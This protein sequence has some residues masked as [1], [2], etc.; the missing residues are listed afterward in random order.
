MII[1]THAHIIVPE[2]TR[3]AQP[4]DRWRPQVRWEG[5]QQ[6]IAFANA[7]IRSAIRECVRIDAILEIQAALGV[8]RIVLS[9]W[10]SLLRY[11]AD[12]QDGLRVSRIQNEALAKLVRGHPDRLS[13]LGTVPLQEP[14]LASRELTRL[15][16]ELGL[17][18]VVIS[19]PAHSISLGDDRFRPFWEIAEATGALV[20]FHP[21]TRGFA[22]PA[23]QNYYL[24]NAVGNPVE[25]TVAAA[26][27]IMAGTMERH[28]RL[29]VLLAHGGGAVIALRGRLRHAWDVQPEA[30]ARLRES[31]ER[32][33]ARFYF[34]SLTQ[35]SKVLQDLIDAV[36]ADH[37][38]LGSDYPFDMGVSDPAAMVRA[39]HLPADDE[40]KILGR[41]AARLLGIH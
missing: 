17:S 18:G 29:K 9:P 37:V 28:P 6:V 2:I 35:D 5:T 22:L 14:A 19:T 11:D 16:E 27:L 41:N 8:D 33:L 1:D 32:S 21:T 40:A 20:F 10:T 25:T 34:D 7:E 39:L 30:R 12:P 3:D 36:G 13:A 15:M 31:P 38:L 24:W 23:L 4:D 26:H